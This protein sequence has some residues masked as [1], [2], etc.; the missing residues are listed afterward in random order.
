[1]G[2][3]HNSD[4]SEVFEDNVMTEVPKTFFFE[5]MQL[6]VSIYFRVNP[7]RYLTIGRRGDRATFSNF[8]AY[9]DPSFMIYVR[10]QDHGRLILS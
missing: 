7:G 1:M 5:G 6:P 3:A 2:D 4:S 8:R 10:S 9:N